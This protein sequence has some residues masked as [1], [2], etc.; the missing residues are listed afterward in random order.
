MKTRK[1]VL[2]AVVTLLGISAAFTVQFGLSQTGDRHAEGRLRL[3]WQKRSS[4][5]HIRTP[6]VEQGRVYL[7]AHHGILSIL[8]MKNGAEIARISPP[9]PGNYESPVIT[10][11]C[12]YLACGNSNMTAIS[13]KT[14]RV[15][16]SRYVVPRDFTMGGEHVEWIITSPAVGEKLVC[17]GSQD[18]NVYALVRTSGEP[19]WKHSVGSMIVSPPLLAGRT[20]Y[21]AS[22]D[23]HIRAINAET[24][25]LQWSVDL[26]E[27]V[28]YGSPRI[29]ED[30]LYVA[31]RRGSVFAVEVA[32]GKMKWKRRV[33]QRFETAVSLTDT[34]LCAADGSGIY[35]LNPRTGESLWSVH[36]GA[37]NP[38][39]YNGFVYCISRKGDLCMIDGDEGGI[40]ERHKVEG[41]GFRCQPVIEA[42]RLVVATAGGVYCFALADNP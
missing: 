19:A 16:W 29:Q 5:K 14:H 15:L 22:F 2:I 33:G 31:G 25:A 30:M 35:G 34:L 13:L 36:E 24:G 40:I 39:V 17:F 27:E 8:D 4:W 32:T 42:E 9:E 23:S 37:E 18:G 11:D 7:M 10:G 41:N 12:L 28:S 3:L 21:V 20:L 1:A 6:A 38:L 26:G